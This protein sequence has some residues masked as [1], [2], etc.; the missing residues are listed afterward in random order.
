M[1]EV[2]ASAAPEA[3]LLGVVCLAVRGLAR[4]GAVLEYDD[5]PG[6]VPGPSSVSS[7]DRI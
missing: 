3:S 4:R 6:T 5:G 1:G 2:V 7:G